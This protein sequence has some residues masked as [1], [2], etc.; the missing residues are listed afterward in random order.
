MSVRDDETR[1]QFV[2]RNFLQNLR[3]TFGLARRR[4]FGPTPISTTIHKEGS[5]RSSKDFIAWPPTN[6]NN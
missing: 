5:I 4:E 2:R 1:C 3:S 6:N